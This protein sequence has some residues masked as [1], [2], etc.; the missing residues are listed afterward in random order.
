[1]SNEEPVFELSLRRR[2]A[3][4]RCEVNGPVVLSVSFLCDCDCDVVTDGAMSRFGLW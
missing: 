3:M 2:G 4:S 1:M